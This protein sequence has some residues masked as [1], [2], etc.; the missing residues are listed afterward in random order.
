MD[1]LTW[2]LKNRKDINRASRREHLSSG[3][4]EQRPGDKNSQGM[5][6]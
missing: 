4:R 5:P 6:R 2:V 3:Q 1:Y